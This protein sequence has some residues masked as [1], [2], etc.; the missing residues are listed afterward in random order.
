[1]SL[2]EI[3][4]TQNHIVSMTVNFMV[5][6]D[7]SLVHIWEK[8]C[9]GKCFNLRFFIVYTQSLAHNIFPVNIFK[10]TNKFICCSI[11]YTS[12]CIRYAFI[13]YILALK[14][15]CT[16]SKFTIYF[17]Q[18]FLSN[19]TKCCYQLLIILQLHT[20]WQKKVPQNSQI[21]WIFLHFIIYVSIY[22]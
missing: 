19:H 8:S 4:L 7:H 3:L 6:W 14:I 1:M 22:C 16:L 9:A 18:K 20:T 15:C 2:Y 10:L 11:T 12:S 21:I 17:V 13:Y 5:T